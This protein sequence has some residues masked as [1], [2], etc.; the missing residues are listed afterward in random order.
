MFAS[1]WWQL[2]SLYKSNEKYEPDWVPRYLLF[3]RSGDLPRVG[4]AAGSAEGFVE[5]PRSA[6]HRRRAG[7]RWPMTAA[8]SPVALWAPVAEELARRDA[9]ERGD[10]RA[11]A[12]GAGTRPPGR[13]STAMRERGWTRTPRTSTART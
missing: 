13:S 8:A 9:E 11:P 10:R 2:E 5:K 4:I 6:V 7:S 12:A 1:R 3:E